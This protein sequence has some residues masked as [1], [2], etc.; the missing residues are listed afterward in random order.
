MQN[1]QEKIKNQIGENRIVLYMKGSKDFPR[2][3]FSASVVQAILSAG[4]DFLDIDVLEDEEIRQGIKEFSNW[5]TL[6]QLYIDGAFIG[7]ADIVL[8]MAENGEL[9]EALKSK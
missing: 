1:V 3:G 2:C 7:G 8:E 9:L 4:F 6:P 5:P